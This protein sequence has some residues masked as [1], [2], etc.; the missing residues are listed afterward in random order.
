M[1][2][3]E[4]I[5]NGPYLLAPAAVEMTLAWET[6]QEGTME[7]AYGIPSEPKR[8]V[9][10]AV[11]RE[12]PCREYEQGCCLYT[13]TLL[14]L[15]P[16]TTYEY[17]IREQGTVLVRASFTTLEERPETVRMVTISDSH[18]F[19]TEKQFSRMIRK[20][21]PDMI[22]HGGDIS[23][24]TGYQRE[25]Y[26]ENWFQKIP[27]VL[28]Q[29][30]VYYVP[31]NH[32]DGPFFESFFTKPQQKRVHAMDN[33][34]A[35]SFDYGPV[36]VVMADSNPWGLFEMNAVNSGLAADEATKTK[37]K[38]ILKWI[39]T[40]LQSEAACQA[41]WRIIVVHHP[42]TD[43]FNNKY[44]VPIAER[45]QANLVLGGHLHY[46]IKAS[47]IDPQQGAKLMY[48][49]QGST[50]EPEASME[51]ITDDKRL[52][53]DFPEVVAVGRNNYGVLEV[54][55]EEINYKLY[56]FSKTGADV[57]VDTIHITHAEPALD[58]HDVTLRRLDNNGRIEVKGQVSNIGT[59]PAIVNVALYDNDVETRINL[60]GPEGNS[61]VLYLEA[62]DQ[63]FFTTIY[64]TK[65]QGQHA[66]R[67][68]DR[69]LN[70]VVFEPE[71]LSFA[72]MKLRTG[73][74]ADSDCLI[75]TIEATNNL[76]RELLLPVPL[77][78]D[79]HM[80]EIKNLF[81]GSHEKKFVEFHYKFQQGGSYQVSIADQ[82]PKQ[83]QIER[84][85]RI[86]PRIRD[87]TGHGHDGLL[88][89]TPKVISKGK[90]VEICFEHYGDYI[91]IPPREDL[92]VPAGFTSMVWAHVDRL[93]RENEMSHNPLM[94]RGRSVGWGATY[95][96]RMVIER[97]GGLKWGTCHDITEYSWQGGR[98]RIG[99][100]MHYSMAF[101]KDRGG[102][103]WCDGVNVAHVSG[104]DQECQL[105]QW[106]TDPI[107]IGYSYIGHVIPEI[108]R[109]K[110]FT[111]LPGRVSQ[112]RFYKAGLTDEE[113]K[114]VFQAPDEKGPKGNALEIWYDFQAIQTAGSH[115]T[116]WR[117]PAVYAPD[118]VTEKQYWAFTR[119]KIDAAVPVQASVKATVEVSDDGATVKGALPLEVKDG[120][121]YVDLSCLPKAQYIR[122]VTELAA[123]A[124]AEGTFIPEV[125]EYEVTASKETE[126]THIFWSTQRDWLR[127]TFTGA[128]GF[129]PVDRLREYPEYTDI[130][131]G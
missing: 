32:D 120:I 85:I 104:I 48:V 26:S 23:F 107:F 68:L 129:A 99:R 36:H 7:A 53:G 130:I 17:E 116:E 126:T 97:A 56:G 79:K 74:G 58:I 29:V 37:I 122:I 123:Q 33:G 88:R 8:I 78:I 113:N 117:H 86:V 2:V 63:S 115:T 81:F 110:Y 54:T 119:L 21:Q 65:T 96:L 60:F 59:V 121:A 9:H 77:Y 108:Q 50:Q 67:V 47:S 52:L 5:R 64:Q 55:A 62:G 105:R 127:G 28:Q 44:I 98:A 15:Q 34:C 57:L 103:S 27:D 1:N 69:K 76:A 70:V 89:G 71:Q 128:A 111:H 66:I 38:D 72:H 61:H 95:L 20:V 30:P 39:E 118:F 125:K 25:Q 51:T 11:T 124:G 6:A 93:A 92:N 18:L 24:G 31:G 3:T 16:G 101:D 22:L 35:F 73:N 41:A 82:I 13:V 94:V 46:Y 131:H 112:V 49:C 4:R 87:K 75:A 12:Q 43:V 40:D 45:C 83:V 114:R 106:E 91:E 102:D 84:G 90:M 42:Y 10:P 14:D 19:H 80:V 100:W 109:P